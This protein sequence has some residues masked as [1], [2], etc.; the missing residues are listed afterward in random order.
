MYIS[1]LLFVGVPYSTK[2]ALWVVYNRGFQL[3]IA[4]NLSS[5]KCIGS[6]VGRHQITVQAS[7]FST[8]DLIIAGV[9]FLHAPDFYGLFLYKINLGKV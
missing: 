9:N 1:Q 7:G 2:P 3:D 4:L 8:I 6:L 5:N